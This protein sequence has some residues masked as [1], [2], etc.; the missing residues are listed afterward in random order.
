MWLAACEMPDLSEANGLRCDNISRLYNS[1][2]CSDVVI[3]CGD[4]VVKAHRTILAA[5]SDTL[6]TAFSSNSSFLEE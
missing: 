1:D 3:K 5:H 4:L 2:N 6:R